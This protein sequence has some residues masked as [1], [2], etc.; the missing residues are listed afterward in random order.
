MVMKLSETKVAGRPDK[1]INLTRPV[2]EPVPRRDVGQ[3][4]AR[5]CAAATFIALHDPSAGLTDEEKEAMRVCLKVW[6]R[7]S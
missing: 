3:M 4:R 1:P 5:A 6:Q 7:L 2:T